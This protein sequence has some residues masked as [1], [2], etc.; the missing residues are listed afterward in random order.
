MSS[1]PR[2]DVQALRSIDKMIYARACL[3]QD[4]DEAVLLS[5]A[6]GVLNKSCHDLSERSSGLPLG[7]YELFYIVSDH[8]SPCLLS[9]FCSDC[10]RL[11]K[12]A[13]RDP[14]WFDSVECMH[15][16]SVFYPCPFP[17]HAY[18][19]L[20]NYYANSFGMFSK[21][22]VQWA[23]VIHRGT[24]SA[25]F[26]RPPTLILTLWVF[27]GPQK[28]FSTQVEHSSSW[29]WRVRGP[30]QHHQIMKSADFEPVAHVGS[31]YFSI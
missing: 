10:H 29:V 13:A 19:M 3:E 24:K 14:F 7:T 30:V 22:R 4:E 6:G 25:V 15:M 16:Q 2:T 23:L 8:F 11:S 27:C 21:N 18:S 26:V 17:A 1:C 5:A 9:L 28:A 31:L 12:A 20:G